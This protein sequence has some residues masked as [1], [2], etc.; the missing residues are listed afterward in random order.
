M[1]LYDAA[2]IASAT[3]DT[4]LPNVTTTSGITILL[5]LKRP[6]PE[7]S[8]TKQQGKPSDILAFQLHG[9][10]QPGYVKQKAMVETTVIEDRT[11]SELMPTQPSET[12]SSALTENELI[13][14]TDE[15]SAVTM[16]Q[17]EEAAK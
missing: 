9:V 2:V 8:P 4:P 1:C 6:V 17:Q 7:G 3:T 12:S 14:L 16:Q 5:N 10:Q 11:A 13:V 15:K